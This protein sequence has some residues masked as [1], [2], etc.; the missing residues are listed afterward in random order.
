MLL[1]LIENMN[2]RAHLC[3]DARPRLVSLGLLCILYSRMLKIE[4]YNFFL[5]KIDFFR[6]FNSVVLVKDKASV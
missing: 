2:P 1:G 4:V 5:R 6:L 3:G